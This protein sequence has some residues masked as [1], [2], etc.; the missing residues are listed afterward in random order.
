VG[1]GKSSGVIAVRPLNYTPWSTQADRWII[2]SSED[3]LIL[4]GGLTYH[5]LGDF[6]GFVKQTA[7]PN[8]NAFHNAIISAL[9]IEEVRSDEVVWIY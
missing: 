2:D 1:I 9:Q 8:H 7:Q 4:S 3:I 6:S 5:N